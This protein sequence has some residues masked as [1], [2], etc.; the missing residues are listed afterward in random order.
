VLVIGGNVMLIKVFTTDRNGKIEFTPKELKELLDEA[1]WEGYKANN[2]NWT[3]TTP[4]WT[5]YYYTTCTDGSATICLNN[6]ETTTGSISNAGTITNGK[7]DGFTYTGT[8]D[9]SIK[10]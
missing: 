3:Y 9:H 5:P 10:L 6:T 7:C 2:K 4:N 1:Y 8:S